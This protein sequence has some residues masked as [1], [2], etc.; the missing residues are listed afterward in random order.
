[1]WDPD[2]NDFQGTPGDSS[3]YL[4]GWATRPACLQLAIPCPSGSVW[5]GGSTWTCVGR[6]AGIRGLLACAFGC[7]PAGRGCSLRFLGEVLASLRD[8]MEELNFSDS[9]TGKKG[10]LS[11]TCFYTSVGSTL[12]QKIHD[13]VSTGAPFAPLP[14][15]YPPDSLWGSFGEL[16]NSIWKSHVGKRSR[17][18]VAESPRAGF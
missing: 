2:S 3:V 15:S 13:C 6:P 7:P 14:F 18:T 9:F 4:W 16:Q 12:R 5:L 11:E 1:M 17:Q 8:Q 10:N